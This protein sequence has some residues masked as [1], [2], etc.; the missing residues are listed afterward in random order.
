MVSGVP[1]VEDR[2]D[3]TALDPTNADE[4]H[5]F[6]SFRITRVI[7]SLPLERVTVPPTLPVVR[8][9]VVLVETELSRRVPVQPFA[10]RPLRTSSSSAR[11]VPGQA[12][13]RAE[14]ALV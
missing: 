4:T 2:V 6:G 12:S 8:P 14:S 13:G 10:R 1:S 3:G 5:H 11:S 7:G 9:L